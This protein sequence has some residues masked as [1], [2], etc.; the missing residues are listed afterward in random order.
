MMHEFH[1]ARAGFLLRE[2]IHEQLIHTRITVEHSAAVTRD[3]EAPLRRGVIVMKGTRE[4]AR[5]EIGVLGTVVILLIGPR[6]REERRPVDAYGLSIC[7]RHMA[8]AVISHKAGELFFAPLCCRVIRKIIL[9][10]IFLR[11]VLILREFLR[12]IGQVVSHARHRRCAAA[13]VKAR[14][15]HDAE[16]PL[17]GLIF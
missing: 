12:H 11:R 6:H 8:R 10:Q 9:R 2:E 17:V 4:R 3:R 16:A 13:G 14:T 1:K 5:S 7:N 15:R